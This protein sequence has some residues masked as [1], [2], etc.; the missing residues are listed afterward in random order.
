MLNEIYIDNFRSLVNFKLQLSHFQLWLGD[1][2]SGKTSVLDVIRRIQKIVEGCAVND[3]FSSD[4]LTSWVKKPTQEFVLKFRV[5]EDNYEYAL[6]IEHDKNKGTCRILT[7]E[8]K[9]NNQTFYLY[10]DGEA[11]LFLINRDSGGV[12]GRP[13]VTIASNRSFLSEIVE[14]PN[15]YPVFRFRKELRN[16]LIVN[17][18][19]VGVSDSAEKEERKLKPHAENFTMWYR[20][21]LQE[22]P[23]IGYSAG[24]YLKEVLPGYE[25]LSL[26]EHGGYRKLRATFRIENSDISFDFSRLSDGQRQLMILYALLAAFKKNLCSILVLDEPDNFVTLR[27]IALWWG[28]LNDICQESSKQA[29]IISHHPT[30]VNQMGHMS[31]TG[32]R[33]AI[34]FSRPNG[35]HTVVKPYENVDGLTPAETM[36]RGWME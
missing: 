24:E 35:S 6:S 15:N 27:E 30:I 17:P 22:D 36:E 9:W 29:V 1:N 8:L 26:N 23:S 25:K 33:N 13:S 31:Q 2:G 28:A 18:I 34:W 21:L 16:C 7:E 20:H 5:E 4:D 12:D 10:K 3:V 19:P 14:H 32:E 11:H